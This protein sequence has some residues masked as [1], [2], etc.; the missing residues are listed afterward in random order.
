MR[1]RKQPLQSTPQKSWCLKLILRKLI[2]HDCYGLNFVL[3]NS[4][5]KDLIPNVMVFGDG[6]FSRWL[7]HGGRALLMGWVS[8][9]N[10]KHKKDPTLFQHLRTQQEDGHLPARQRALTRHQISWPLD[11]ELLSFQTVRNKCLLVKSPFLGYFVTA[12][13]D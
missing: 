9:Y 7:S 4:C 13:A 1:K 11:P 3:P 5:V 8:S 12:W 6:S 10:K 2:Y